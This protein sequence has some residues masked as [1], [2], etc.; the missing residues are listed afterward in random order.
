MMTMERVRIE[1]AKLAVIEKKLLDLEKIGKIDQI[2]NESLFMVDVTEVEGSFTNA[3]IHLSTILSE[4]EQAVLAKS[5]QVVLEFA[6]QRIEKE[7]K[8]V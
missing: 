1:K 3:P 7:T 5:I 4:S 6:K 8:T 2:L